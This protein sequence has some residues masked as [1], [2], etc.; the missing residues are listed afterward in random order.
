MLKEQ[1]QPR[2]LP[3]KVA[4]QPAHVPV[5][6]Q[7]GRPCWTRPTRRVPTTHAGVAGRHPPT[8]RTCTSGIETCR[9]LKVEIWLLSMSAW[10]VLHATSA[11]AIAEHRAQGCRAQHVGAAARPTDGSDE[12]R[13]SR[14]L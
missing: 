8:R 11:L 4:P 14:K 7:C 3:A 12:A 10:K 13:C 2:L 1:R 9:S 6:V 5:L